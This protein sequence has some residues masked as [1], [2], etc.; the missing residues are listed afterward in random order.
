M[1]QWRYI[2]QSVPDKEF[3]DLDVPLTNVTIT[4][5][6]SGPGDISG[7]L[8][9]Q[10]SALK[11]SN[12][13]LAISEYGTM[14]HVE[15][16]GEI[17]SSGIVDTI[18]IQNDS[19]SISAGGFSVYPS[20]QPYL[21]KKKEFISTDPAEIIRFAWLWLLD[22]PD[23]LPDVSID[24]TTTDV[25]VGKPEGREL[26]ALK[27]KLKAEKRKLETLEKSV[28]V[29]N[30]TVAN[31]K[32]AVYVAAKRLTV[33]EIVEQ[34]SQ[35]SGKKAVKNNLW[36]DTDNGKIYF[37]R[38][39]WQEITYD[40]G[41]INTAIANY[42]A[43]KTNYDASVLKVKNHIESIKT[44]ED[45]IRDRSEDEAEPIVLSW[46]TT[47]DI[48]KVINDMVDA[49]G[50]EYRERSFWSGDDIHYRLEM[51]TPLGAR[52]NN[53][54]FEIGQN[55]T[56]VPTVKLTDY[57]SG[58]LLLGSGE[59]DKRIHSERHSNTGKLRKVTVQSAPQA[60]TK[61]KAETEAKNFLKESQAERSIDQITVVNHPLAPF[62]TYSPGDEI[63]V[64]GD[65]GWADLDAFVRIRKI[66]YSPDTDTAELEVTVV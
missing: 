36:R 60:T 5:A 47:D 8:P 23:A 34:A 62:G 56:V 32:K 21:G 13:K 31:A 50:L 17:I 20:E 61:A 16:D 49:S 45:K 44:I 38:D 46:D 41:P 15:R 37:Y 3:V 19:L 24:I 57:A 58:C 4:D 28:Q 63:H 55:V 33:G 14:L 12:G 29:G 53:I 25:T 26:T 39:S 6:I 54:Y 27:D 64:A 1:S 42:R 40:N 22:F 43:A 48:Q 30:Q 10:Y 18:E 66:T 2:L 35:P 9:I 59:G 51:G 11:K 65:A 52:R 7:T